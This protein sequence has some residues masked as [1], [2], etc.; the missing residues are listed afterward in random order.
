MKKSF[1]NS[2]LFCLLIVSMSLGF[3]T[4]SY[5]QAVVSVDPPLLVSPS[6]GQQ[7]T[8]N[9]KITNARNV[10]G[11][12]AT[13]NFDSS[14][15]RYVSSEYADYLPVGAFAIPPAVSGSSVTLGE[16][17]VA[18]ATAAS[19]SGTLATVR[20]EVV[21]SKTSTI[22]L[23]NVVLADS[24]SASL[25]VSMRN[26]TIQV[27]TLQPSAQEWGYKDT[28]EGHTDVVRTLAFSPDG[29]V[30][31]S[32]GLDNT[33]RLWNPHTGQTL[34]ILN[35][36]KTVSAVAFSPDGNTLASAC[37][38]H[39]VYLWN[40]RTRRLT[41]TLVGHEDQ[42]YAVAYSR[43]GKLASGGRDNTVRL[44]NTQTGQHQILRRHTDWVLSVAF[45]PIGWLASAG[46]DKE[47][48]V[49]YDDP[50]NPFFVHGPY[51]TYNRHT[52]F[53][54]SVVFGDDS[55]FTLGGELVTGSRDHS[56]KMTLTPEGPT[57]FS[58]L[59]TEHA[60]HVNSVAISVDK[61]IASGSADGTV[62][63]W[64]GTA[65][66]LGSIATLGS[67]NSDG[68]RAVA[69]SPDGLRL[70]SGD[71][72]GNVVLYERLGAEVV[73]Y[74]DDSITTDEISDDTTGLA[75]TDF[76]YK[77]TFIRHTGLVRALAFSP[78]N[79]M[80]ASGG[81]DTII[82]LWN[83]ATG[84]LLRTLP[85]HTRNITSVVF[86]PDNRLLASSSVDGSIR[87]WNSQTGRQF[88]SVPNAHQGGVQ[89]VDF[90]ADGR[91]LASGGRDNTV[92][93]WDSNTGGLV[94]TLPGHTDWVLEVAFSQ[95]GLLATA[96]RDRTIRLWSSNGQYIRSLRGH[97]DFVTSVAFASTGELVSGS[98]D[99]TVRS[100]HPETGSP[101]RVFRGHTYH[102]N[103]VS[104]SLD[105][106][107]ASGSTAV[108]LWDLQTG[109]SLGTLDENPDGVRVVAFSADGLRLA[110]G[111]ASGSIV[112]YEGIG[113]E[114]DQAAVD[115][116]AVYI[117]D[118][119]LRT[120]LEAALD[121]EHRAPITA[122]EILTLTEFAPGPSNIQDLTGLEYA[123]NLTKLEFYHSDISDLTPL[124]GLINLKTLDLSGND[125]SDLSPLAGLINLK[126]LDL[127]GN[128]ISDVSP[129]A[130]LINLTKLE[131]YY[132]QI[133][134]LAPLAGLINL[135]ELIII[136][137]DIS[138]VSPLAGLINLRVLNLS[139]N[140]IS[141]VSPLAGLI[142]LTELDLS[143]NQIWD[144]SS[145][146]RLKNLKT[147]HIGNNPVSIVVVPP[148]L[149]L[150]TAIEKALDKTPGAA[151]K[152]SDMLTLTELKVELAGIQ[153]LTGL[154]YAANLERLDLRN[155]KILD[156]APLAGLTNLERLDLRNNKILDIA[157]LTG[158]PNLK[159]LDLSYNNIQDFRPI[160]GLIPNLEVYAD[161]VRPI[162]V[163]PQSDDGVPVK[164]NDKLLLGVI[165][166]DL[167]RSA[168][169]E[170]EILQAMING[171]AVTSEEDAMITRGMM[172][173]LSKLEVRFDFPSGGRNDL[174]DLTG[175]EYATNLR[176]LDFGTMAFAGGN[177]SDLS[178]LKS[179]T[180][181]TDLGIPNHQISD[182][183]PLTQ[184]KQLR[185]LRLYSNEISDV[186]PL[187]Q[188][189]QLRLLNLSENQISDVSGLS[190]LKLLTSLRLSENQISDITSL[191]HLKYLTE[192]DLSEN[193]ISDITSLAH[194][195]YLTKLN[196]SGN[197]ISD[198]SP[199]AEL[200][201]LTELNL[202]KNRILDFSPIAD[203]I[204]NLET[205]DETAQNSH[206]TAVRIHSIDYSQQ[207]TDVKVRLSST[208]VGAEFEPGSSH[209]LTYEVTKDNVP[210]IGLSLSLTA[211]S[212]NSSASATFTLSSIITG[213]GG[214]AE[215][216]ITFGELP[217]EIKLH[218]EVKPFSTERTLNQYGTTIYKHQG[219][220]ET[221]LI[222]GVKLDVPTVGLIQHFS[223]NQNGV[224][225][226]YYKV[227]QPYTSDYTQ[228]LPPDK[229]R[230]FEIMT[231][232]GNGCGQTSARMLLNY[233]GIDVS[234]TTFQDVGDHY[235]YFTNEWIPDLALK[236][237]GGADF[238]GTSAM[239]M[240][241]GISR[242]GVPVNQYIA[243]SPRDDLRNYI[244][245]SRPVIIVQRLSEIGYH[246]IV[247]IGYDTRKDMFLIADPNGFFYWGYWDKWTKVTGP[248]GD[249]KENQYVWRPPLRTSWR[250]D[251]L[252]EDAV[253][254]FDVG[255]LPWEDWNG[256]V[257]DVQFALMP[258]GW[259]RSY[260]MFVPMVAPKYHHLESETFEVR[261]YG[262][263]SLLV[264]DWKWHD[265]NEER[266]VSGRV[267]DFLWY[268]EERAGKTTDKRKEGNKVILSGG[269]QRGAP[270]DAN[271]P[272]IEE[273]F[274][275]FIDG[276]LTVYYD[277]SARAA[278][279]IILPA[280][281][282]ATALLPNYPNPFNPETWI[283]YQL[284]KPSDVMLRIYSVD[285]KLVRT[286][287]L[288]YQAAGTYHE[289]SN[290]VYW[291][292]RNNVGERVASGIYFY[293]ITAGDFTATRKM[294]IMK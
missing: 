242:L 63:L 109:E 10:A 245:Q 87:L 168:G 11:Y 164:I 246:H 64:D 264:V 96:S 79:Q 62:R 73:D 146:E 155:N 283:P 54:T 50:N 188:L 280:P 45:S 278:P 274:R 197:E 38:D 201:N 226:E 279:S 67:G 234:Q 204:P 209:K 144:V 89:S 153:D 276:V 247:V 287:A 293:T 78:D 5:G 107:I 275:G 18:G 156:I 195:K 277:P 6:V 12:Q 105:G 172:R 191:A 268:A 25:P 190:Q 222:K 84:T 34:A 151:I 142:N 205:Y 196:L 210:V 166:D 44:W 170:F 101:L 83:P 292:G 235:A 1:K 128:D 253:N 110:S 32:G 77:D 135:T 125:I 291:D 260:R 137:G 181:L 224:V 271:I 215:T 255:F 218:A 249:L 265:W 81:A 115:P 232:S 74:V 152:P 290:A 121:K 61:I 118:I 92:R 117:P 68:V 254:D 131:F 200:T 13:V 39:K 113:A 175:L 206:L 179:L 75:S 207:G 119:A 139:I 36:P 212:H 66:S 243:D 7:L 184:L 19:S 132:S 108:R 104:V 186:S 59:Y 270:I 228:F 202:S 16:S 178:P 263:T 8:I 56:V 286:L 233:Y 97:T 173:Q 41:K 122:A 71:E 126:T 20:F 52:D 148:D 3:A 76:T 149:N 90:S 238:V 85:G 88:W 154:E 220:K 93:L 134:D 262:E 140:R 216:Y 183:S 24:N 227:H 176:S 82:H 51:D 189:T 230:H 180:Y 80:L 256:G 47:V 31:A 192:L 29:Q 213:A 177:V 185:S 43:T 281:Q 72:S 208:R 269:I 57:S 14:A 91:L 272:G 46:R 21:A 49:W 136:G 236:L 111:D 241:D 282:A 143:S 160:A 174:H 15:L 258:L 112:L 171:E 284:S 288:G 70:A 150:R 217:G 267:I 33:I 86:S 17:S 40:V 99:L 114:L 221:V 211:I 147:F 95:T 53:V 23:T 169:L 261:V 35:H 69:F 4:L 187:D 28:F 159:W 231:Q 65:D 55:R 214:E 102:V 285:G 106:T 98:R 103:H 133:S 116:D 229:G 248:S 124:A 158:L 22:R 194:L 251:Y 30:L 58:Y 130:G 294:L 163:S 167:P 2:M 289:K 26:G 165:A 199:L 123:K 37:Q 244:S 129:L 237:L 273:I 203:L 145:L 198:V 141:D 162:L 266:T 193:Q 223:V 161:D 250:L 42:V 240:K 138:D 239:A 252:P 27:G 219:G 120:E 182:L 9:L 225:Y 259:V 48:I 94:R 157:P 127:S 60:G 100:W 257:P